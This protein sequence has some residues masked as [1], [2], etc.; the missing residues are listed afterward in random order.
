MKRAFL[1]LAMLLMGVLTFAD[2]TITISANS[3][4]IS[5]SLDLRVVAKL[6]AEAS[7]TEQFEN[8]L[9]N[10]D[11]T[12]SNLDLNGDNQIDYLRVVEAGTADSK[13]IVIQ[14]V[15]AKDIYQDVASIYVE[16]DTKTQE[17]SVQI[18]GDEYIYG[19][20]YII[21]PVYVYRPVIYSWFWSPRWYCWESPWYWGYWPSWWYYR[22][23]YTY[24]WYY[25]RCYR[26]HHYHHHCCSFRHGRHP[27]HNYHAVHNSVSRRDYAVSH[28]DNSFN[29]RHT[30][31]RNASELRR[32]SVSQ[33]NG[34][35][36]QPNFNY[37]SSR[38]FNSRNT[39]VQ[40]SGSSQRSQSPSVSQRSDD[41]NQ[42][43]QTSQTQRTA[44]ASV[45][46]QRSTSQS[47]A[48]RTT[49]TR[50]SNN[51]NRPT[52]STQQRTNNGQVRTSSSSS[53]RSS[54]SHNSSHSRSSS[55]GSTTR[56]SGSYNGSSRSSGSVSRSAGSYSGGSS[57]SSGGSVSRSSGSGGSS[58]RR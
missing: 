50:S 12:F 10:P 25:D 2:E 6:F 51:S 20:N 3:E 44:T 53:Y 30:D 45:S 54:G 26:F 42:R 4:D 24:H 16:K 56:S 27:H 57:R 47:G 1:F 8:M 34:G 9:N 14:A 39:A 36:R 7:T 52:V 23:C 55:A 49:Q 19:T 35:V 43:T 5:Q 37:T 41:N 13:L 29:R 33:R 15:L 28:A 38:T 17:V 58:R 48:S 21:E 32:T 11:S 40:R 18:I 31:V 46:T 22:S